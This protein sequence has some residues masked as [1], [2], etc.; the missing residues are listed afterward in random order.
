MGAEDSLIEFK[1]AGCVG[2]EGVVPVD[3]LNF[4]S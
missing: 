4:K 2:A 3:A 1:S